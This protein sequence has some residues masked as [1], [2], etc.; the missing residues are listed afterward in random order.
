[1]NVM[2]YDVAEGV[3]AGEAVCSMV[4]GISCCRIETTTT[5]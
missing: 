5:L 3:S 4:H 1:M 2:G